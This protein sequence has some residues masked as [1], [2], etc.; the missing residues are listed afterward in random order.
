MKT[1]LSLLILTA[2]LA[3]EEPSMTPFN[4]PSDPLL[5][6]TAL[7]VPPEDI[8]SPEIQGLINTM[9]SIAQGERTEEGGRVMVGLAAPQIGILKRIILVDIGIEQT[10]KELGTL[11]VFI[12]PEIISESSEL[13]EG[14]EGCFSVDHHVVGVVP[15]AKSVKIR[16][17][18]RE[19]QLITGEYTDYTA[20]IFQ[21]EI[22]HLNGIR[23]PDKIEQG[24]KLHW[25]EETEVENY[26]QNWENWTHLVSQEEWNGM[27]TGALYNK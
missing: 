20:R 27:K 22:D 14:K 2:T 9:F 5:Q 26:R 4:H 18:N 6:S 21:H 15:R 17:Y 25:V 10:K 11:T 12:N 19:G 13:V 7:S 8:Q 24:A 23:F 3:A 1:L 16:A